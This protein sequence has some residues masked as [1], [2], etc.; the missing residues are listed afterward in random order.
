MPVVTTYD[1][2]RVSPSVDRRI[3]QG[4]TWSDVLSFDSRWGDD[5][6]GFAARA[7]LRRRWADQSGDNV[8]ALFT[9]MI[10]SFGP[11]NRVVQLYLS[12]E[13]TQSVRQARGVWD[14]EIYNG[15]VVHR[16]V[17]GTWELSRETT[18]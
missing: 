6:T 3:I 9:A 8:L 17:Q 12:A 1:L 10:V 13:D 14:C 11:S 2:I 15:T 4:S 16:I 5:W 18:R 7:Q